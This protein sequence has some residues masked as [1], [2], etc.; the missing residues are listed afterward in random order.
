VRQQNPRGIVALVFRVYI[1]ADGSRADMPLITSKALQ[2][3]NA[4]E[5]YHYVR[6]AVWR[7]RRG[8]HRSSKK[9]P[10]GA[11]AMKK[12]GN[13]KVRSQ[14]IGHLS[15]GLGVIWSFCLR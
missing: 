15:V 10:A 3:E 11:R 6:M 2:L 12:M 4:G 8:R 14:A 7:G 1:P 5:T 13:S 9:S